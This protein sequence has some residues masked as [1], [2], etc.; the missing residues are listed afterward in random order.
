MR[1][2]AYFLMGV[3]HAQLN[4]GPYIAKLKGLARILRILSAESGWTLTLRKL[5]LGVLPGMMAAT[6]AW[7]WRTDLSVDVLERPVSPKTNLTAFL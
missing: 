3:I 6:L 2:V 4:M 5:P 1:T 7:C